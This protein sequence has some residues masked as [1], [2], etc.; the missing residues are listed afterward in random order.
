MRI[1]VKSTK[2][3]GIIPHTP[4][5]APD[6]LST[7]RSSSTEQ[8]Y[9]RLSLAVIG[10]TFLVMLFF[11]TAAFFL[12]VRGAER[13]VVPQVVNGELTEALVKL[14]ER[15]LY[16][17]LQTKYTGNP[18]DKGLVIAQNPEAGLYVKAGRR[19]TITVSSGAVVD[20]VEDYIGKT[21][22]E[23]RG[24]LA[25]LFTSFEPLLAV[26]EPVTYVYDESPVGTVISQTP[27]AGTPLSEPV[28]LVLIVSRGP[29]D[30]PLTLPDWRDWDADAAIR[31][32]AAIPLP[33]SFIEDDAGASGSSP[34]VTGQLPAPGSAVE[35]GSR[36]TFTYSPP[37]SCS[38]G[39]RCG[40]F[41]Y[42]L[43]DFPVPVLLEVILREPGV[44]DRMMFSMFHSGG[45]VSFPYVL[46]AGTGIILMINGSQEYRFDI[47]AEG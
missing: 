42:T 26:R 20:N 21:F 31:S 15:E 3:E 16:A 8:R 45:A 28:E 19:V 12:A 18:Q 27:E 25:T 36:V 1:D 39:S 30:P 41:E 37:E 6:T 7:Q 17:R 5:A 38:E 13:T 23:V 9:F 32:I 47:S 24:R 10:I 2:S 46:P 4:S 44:E 40:L 22:D 34:R 35:K 14:Q 33:F 11:F 43:R 29:A